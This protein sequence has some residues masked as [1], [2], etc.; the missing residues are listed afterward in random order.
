MKY[1]DPRPYADPERAA[2]RIVELA[3]A[4]EP[5][6]DGRTHVEKINGP[7]LFQDGGKPAEYSAGMALCIE[8]GW[9]KMHRSGTFVTFTSAGA[10]LFS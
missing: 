6:Q 2:R 3:Q 1:T 10:A 8:R 4:V 9:L 5:V 7:F